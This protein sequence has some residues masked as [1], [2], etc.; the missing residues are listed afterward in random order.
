MKRTA[1]ERHAE[2]CK[3]YGA[4]A[5]RKRHM[6]GSKKAK[7][8]MSRLTSAELERLR[9]GQNPFAVPQADGTVADAEA[10]VVADLPKD[11]EVTVKL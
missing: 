2:L 5:E 1:R 8:M 6:L 3:F 11:E 9:G 7:R 4:Q 10:T